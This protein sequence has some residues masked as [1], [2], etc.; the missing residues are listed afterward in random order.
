MEERPA[1]PREVR[2]SEPAPGPIAPGRP[3]SRALGRPQALI[4]EQPARL[5]LGHECP[6]TCV[7]VTPQ[8]QAHAEQRRPVAWRLRPIEQQP[9]ARQGRRRLR[10]PAAGRRVGP[11]FD[12]GAARDRH[13]HTAAPGPGGHERGEVA[14][15]GRLVLRGIFEPFFTTKEV[16]QGTGLGLATVY[17]IVQAERR[18]R[19]GRQRAREG[20]LMSGYSHEAVEKE[21]LLE[22]GTRLLARPFSL[23]TLVRSVEEALA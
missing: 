7:G 16:G 15:Q 17:G 1:S 11:R 4:G 5:D 13:R 23:N 19:V 21:G 6:P 14:G 10:P 20:L 22:P 2:P 8:R 12:V 9:P 18:V 3:A